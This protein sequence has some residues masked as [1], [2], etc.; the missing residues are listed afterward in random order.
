MSEKRTKRYV[1][2]FTFALALCFLIAD[3]Y[4]SYTCAGGLTTTDPV[5]SGKH[6]TQAPPQEK[7][8]EQT[9]KNIQVLKGLPESQLFSLMNFV[10][11]SLGVRCNYCHVN[12]GGDNW[13]WDSDD[14]ESKRTARQ[15]MRMVLD[16]NKN[17]RADFRGGAITCYTCHRGQTTPL[18]LP[19]LPLAQS[20]HE[21][22]G[23]ASAAKAKEPLPAAEQVISKYVAAV[24]GRERVARLKTRV[25]KGMREASQGRNWPMEVYLKGP[26]KFLAVITIPQQGVV[27]Q[28]YDGGVGWLKNPGTQRLASAD[29]LEALKQT[30]ALYEVIKVKEAPSELKLVGRERVGEREAY[31]LQSTR[32]NRIAERLYVDV[33]SGLLLRKLVLTDTV[34][35]PIP[36]QIDFEDYRDVDGVMLPFTIRISNI[37]TWFSSTR[38]FTEVKH[39]GSIDDARF[40]MPSPK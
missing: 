30:A 23:E 20:G 38:R 26:D 6:V 28:G 34:L 25:L 11:A 7:P 5:S 9:R 24:G 3:R 29:E 31:V 27:Q 16:I 32:S 17:N 19:P 12:N 15:M 35:S 4:A 18:H 10:S 36:E 39:N 37:D 14:K 1:I 2:N 21:S 33:E 40:K 22:E 13:V 8:V